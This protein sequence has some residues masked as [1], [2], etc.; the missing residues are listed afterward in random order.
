[1]VLLEAHALEQLRRDASEEPGPAQQTQPA[2][3]RIA[4][5]QQLAEFLPDPFRGDF[6]ED[7]QSPRNGAPR[8]AIER[9]AQRGRESDRA[10]WP[11]SEGTVREKWLG[12]CRGSQSI[13]R[14][15]TYSGVSSWPCAMSSRSRPASRAR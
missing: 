12:T 15:K 13:T 6:R 11:R 3:R 1:L 10:R 7:V 9:E 5:H 8:R 4:A 2:A 14:S